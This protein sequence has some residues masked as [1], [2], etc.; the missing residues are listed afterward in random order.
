MFQLVSFRSD[1]IPE[2]KAYGDTALE[3]RARGEVEAGPPGAGF[4]DTLLGGAILWQ[5]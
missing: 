2:Y 3:R 4:G 5:K 1:S